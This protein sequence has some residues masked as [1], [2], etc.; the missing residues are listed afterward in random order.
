[1]HK[2][3]RYVPNGA[4]RVFFSFVKTVCKM[5]NIVSEDCTN[6]Y[7]FTVGHNMFLHY[8]LSTRIWTAARRITNKKV[9]KQK[10]CIENL[11]PDFNF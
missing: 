11:L 3:P 8:K 1:M 6:H 2:K 5:Q 9:G 10:F 4:Y 7:I